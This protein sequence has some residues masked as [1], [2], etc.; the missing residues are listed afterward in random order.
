M[1]PECWRRPSNFAIKGPMA[2]TATTYI[3][4]AAGVLNANK[5]PLL[6]LAGVGLLLYVP[7]DPEKGSAFLFFLPV[8]LLFILYPLVYGQ[9]AEIIT[10]HR[11]APYA[12][13]FRT[14]WWN[15]FF[16][17]VVIGIPV[18]ILTLFGAHMKYDALVFKNFG[19]ILVDIL[20]I[21]VIPLVFLLRKRLKCIPLGLKCLMGNFRFSRPLIFLSLIP[22]LFVMMIRPLPA[23]AEYALPAMMI[24][25]LLWLV[26]I[27]LDCLVFIAAALILREK[28]LVDGG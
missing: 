27:Y 26:S 5:A 9:Y 25:Y 17:S 16:V 23:D 11:Q 15:Y 1:R 8:F 6:I 18:L 12:D 7:K 20:T 14:H 10:H 3:V 21:Y 19:A 28:L 22:S 13:I 24:G 4:K 2:P